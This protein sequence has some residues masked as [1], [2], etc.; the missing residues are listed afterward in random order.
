MIQLKYVSLAWLKSEGFVFP[1]LIEYHGLKKL[2]DMKGTYYTDLVKKIYTTTHTDD[3][4]GFSCVEVQ[5][6]QIV[7]TLEV[8]LDI[9]GLLLEGVMMNQLVLKELDLFSTTSGS[10]SRR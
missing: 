4:I 7:M 5:G 1:E 6:K 9:V 10:T 2:V 3:D 8:W